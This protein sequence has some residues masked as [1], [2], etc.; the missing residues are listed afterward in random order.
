M[1]QIPKAGSVQNEMEFV[2]FAQFAAFALHHFDRFS[3][4]AGQ[5]HLRELDRSSPSPQYMI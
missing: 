5:Q 4:D 1:A 2:V 3:V